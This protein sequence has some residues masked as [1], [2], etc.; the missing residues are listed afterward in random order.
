MKGQILNYSVQTNTGVITTDDGHRYT[1]TGDQWRDNSVPARGMLVDFV[2][3]GTFATDIYRA[4]VA[5]AEGKSRIVAGVLGIILGGL[6]IHK[7][8]LGYGGPGVIMLIV[9]LVGM[10]PVFLG[11]IAISII[12][13]IEGI[14]YLTKT[15]EEFEQEYILRRKDWF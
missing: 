1:F 9:F 10:L 13:M 5:G 14:I 4:I 2:A 15:D 3:E 6:G 12:G 7:F 8:Y 11:T